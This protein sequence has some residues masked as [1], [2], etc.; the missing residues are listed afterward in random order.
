MS[1]NQEIFSTDESVRIIN[2]TPENTELRAIGSGT[3]DQR[4]FSNWE[5]DHL[6]WN[7]PSS[8]VLF[9]DG[10]LRFFAKRLSNQRRTGLLDSGR[11]FYATLEF[12]FYK[13]FDDPR[14]FYTYELPVVRLSWKTRVDDYQKSWLLPGLIPYFTHSYISVTQ[15]WRANSNETPPV[16]IPFPTIEF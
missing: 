9:D 8:F 4:E 3:I 6:H 10:E 15:H 13:K 5:P 11:T 2:P 14:P 7:V 1:E 16:V 12:K